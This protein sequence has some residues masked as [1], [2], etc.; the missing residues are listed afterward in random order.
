MLGCVAFSVFCHAA[1]ADS[2]RMRHSCVLDTAWD[3]AAVVLC[4]EWGMGEA[5][6]GIIV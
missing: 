6:L 4:I 2:Y 3:L 5:K 1:G